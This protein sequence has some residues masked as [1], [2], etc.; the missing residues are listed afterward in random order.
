MKVISLVIILVA[1]F[2]AVQ[3]FRGKTRPFID[4]YPLVP[5]GNGGLILPGYVRAKNTTQSLRTR[6]Y[7]YWNDIT[8]CQEAGGKLPV[9]RCK[10][11]Q[12]PMFPKMFPDPTPSFAVKMGWS[13]PEPTPGPARTFIRT[14]TLPAMTPYSYLSGPQYRAFLKLL[15]RN[16]LC[17]EETSCK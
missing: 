17:T 1:I 8:Y 9:A 2:C 3:C 13:V 15:K 6:Q 12:F 14:L 10:G 11:T 4:R 5:D 16:G 7:I